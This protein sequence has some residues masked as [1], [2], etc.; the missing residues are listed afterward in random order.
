MNRRGSALGVVVARQ[1][2]GAPVWPGKALY[3]LGAME[4]GQTKGWCARMGE[5]M[6]WGRWLCHGEESGGA[7]VKGRQ[8]DGLTVNGEAGGGVLGCTEVEHTD[9]AR[10]SHRRRA[11]T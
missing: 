6:A 9:R 5:V 3:G 7:I 4:L 10:G 1:C 8:L 11:T 2:A